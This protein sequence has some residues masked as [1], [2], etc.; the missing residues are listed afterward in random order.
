M[1]NPNRPTDDSAWE[2]A[3]SRDFDA[4][5]RDLH[6]A[7][8]DLASVKGKAMT[9]QRNRRIAVAGGV[10]AAAAVIVPVAAIAV[11]NGPGD[12]PEPPVATNSKGTDAPSPS[13]PTVT[14][15][16]IPDHPVGGGADYVLGDVWYRADGSQ[17]QLPADHDYFGA[18]VW[19]DQLVATRVDGEV[20]AAADVIDADG[21]VVDTFD[22]TGPVVVNDA[23]TTIAWIDTDGEVMTR[24]DGGEVSLGNVDLA[25]AGEG[26]AWTAAAV[27]G[28]PDCH[29]AADGCVVYLNSGLGEGSTAYDSHGIQD[30]PVPGALKFFDATETGEVTAVTDATDVETCSGLYRVQD[31]GA[32]WETCDYQAQQISP[33]GSYVAGLP[34]Y[35]D[36]LGPV[37][38]SVLD[39]TDGT[40]T[41]RYAPEGGFIATWA[42]AEDGRLLFTAHDGASWHLFAMQPDGAIEE[43]T[44]PVKGKEYADPFVL[45]QQ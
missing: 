11:S 35:F 20:Y 31:A 9:I 26:V 36:G 6:E 41:G 23:H 22:T 38:I 34:S 1:T 7:P 19:D 37:S 28:G 10:L 25:A 39:A 16:A 29:E 15:T 44:D 17:V 4:R 33:D 32:A 8:L 42:W 13:D 43:L 45:V 40:E 3:M 27:T 14:D 5:V 12:E 21:T 24:W 18:V 2:S 30:S